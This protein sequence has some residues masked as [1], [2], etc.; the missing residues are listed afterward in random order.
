M[1][2]KADP[3]RSAFYRNIYYSATFE[4]MKYLYPRGDA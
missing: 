3:F 4:Y 1:F 2:K